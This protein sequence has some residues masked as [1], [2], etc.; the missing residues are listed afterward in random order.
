MHTEV[1]RFDSVEEMENEMEALLEEGG[2]YLHG[3]WKV[4]QQYDTK[5]IMA[6]HGGLGNPWIHLVL[7]ILTGW[8]LMLL[9]N[10]AY[11]GTYYFLNSHYLELVVKRKPG[12]SSY[13]SSK[14]T[15]VT[16]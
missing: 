13:R 4:W 8:W 6:Y 2:D 14:A 5:V 10:L 9:P 15:R 7:F 12:E 11:A 16:T 3:C 1:M